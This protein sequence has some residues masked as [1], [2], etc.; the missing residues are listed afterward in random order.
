MSFWSLVGYAHNFIEDALLRSLVLQLYD[1]Q[2]PSPLGSLALVA[3]AHLFL[4]PPWSRDR[5]IQ[6]CG[7]GGGRG[8]ARRHLG[9][10]EH[11]RSEGRED[12]DRFVL[13]GEPCSFACPF[14]CARALI[15][16]S[17]LHITQ[18]QFLI[19]LLS[20]SQS[21]AGARRMIHARTLIPVHTSSA[22][23]DENE[24][25]TVHSNV[26]THARV[27]VQRVV[28]GKHFESD[29]RGREKCVHI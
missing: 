15:S 13:S 6:P 21:R 2:H 16:K 10:L 11:L 14:S 9:I 26:H 4:P 29:A 23:K 18:L 19:T 7:G 27:C 17:E 8:Q 3:S 24:R 5:R 25:R 22:M 12:R 28:R 20:V 1:A